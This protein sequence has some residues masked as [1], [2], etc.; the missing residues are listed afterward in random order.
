MVTPTPPP[1]HLQ[2]HSLA[3]AIPIVLFPRTSARATRH[4][5]VE[6]KWYWPSTARH[7]G[8]V[9]LTQVHARFFHVDFV[10]PANS[11]FG[12]GADHTP[13]AEITVNPFVDAFTS[14]A[15]FTIVPQ[16]GTADH[17]DTLGD[18]IMTPMV[19]LNSAGTES[20]WTYQT[21]CTNAN[22]TRPTGISWYQFDVTGG[23]FPATPVQ[24]Q[25]WTNNNDGLYRFMSSIAVDNSVTRSLAMQHQVRLRSLEFVMQDASI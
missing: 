23:N 14:A 2:S 13:N 9:S 8:G 1:S 20:L 17:I 24:Q 5:P 6:M 19:Y 7:S 25:T 12:V 16:Q 3:S 18:K 15:G 4:P 10:T 21:V 11:T 22:C